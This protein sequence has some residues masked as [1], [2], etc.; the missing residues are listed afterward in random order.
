MIPPVHST[1]GNTPVNRD[2]PGQDSQAGNENP[3]NLDEPGNMGGPGNEGPI[4]SMPNGPQLGGTPGGQL[5]GTGLTRDLLPPAPGVGETDILAMLVAMR[6]QMTQA[7]QRAAEQG[8]RFEVE[9]ATSKAQIDIL[10]Q[11]ATR[12]SAVPAAATTPALNDDTGKTLHEQH[13]HLLDTSVVSTPNAWCRL[14]SISSIPKISI[15]F[16]R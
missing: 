4:T 3:A 12:N 6:E 7:E 5:C 10:A 11:L 16:P 14:S 9:R 13:S 2:L 1:R 15:S 8:C